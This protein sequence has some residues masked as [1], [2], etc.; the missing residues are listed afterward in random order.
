MMSEP[1]RLGVVVGPDHPAVVADDGR[2]LGQVQALALGQALDD[3]DE[4]DVGETGLG[5]PLGGRRA[6]VAGADDGDLVP[7]HGRVWTSNCGSWKSGRPFYGGPARGLR[8]R[9]PDVGRRD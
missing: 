4:D 5:D 2:R 3:V 8:G 7:G 1:A 9:R 6:D